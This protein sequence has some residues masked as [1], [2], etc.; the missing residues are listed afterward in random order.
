MQRKLS[1]DE[2]VSREEGRLGWAVAAT[3]AT[4]AAAE[5]V[6]AAMAGQLAVSWAERV[7]A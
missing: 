5:P 1:Q 3:A 7:V 6:A 4:L 2:E